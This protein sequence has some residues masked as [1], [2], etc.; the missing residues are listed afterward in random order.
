MRLETYEEDL[1]LNDTKLTGIKEE[2]VWDEVLDFGIV[3]NY[4]VCYLHDG[5]EG[6]FNLVISLILHYYCIKTKSKDKKLLLNILNGRLKS[7]DYNRNDIS[8]RPTLV[9][10][11]ELK[12]KHLSMSGTEMHNFLLIFSMLVVDIVQH[13]E[14]WNLYLQMRQIM[15]LCS[16]RKFQKGCTKFMRTLV[17]EFIAMFKNPFPTEPIKP[18]M[19]NLTHYGTILEQSGPIINLSTSKYETKHNDKKKE[20]SAANSRVNITHTLCMEESLVLCY[21]FLSKGNLSMNTDYGP[22]ENFDR[23]SDF[24]LY[25]LFKETVLSNFINSPCLKPPWIE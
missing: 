17:E 1:V 4:A 11:V 3:E 10:E 21:R 2:S 7:F 22:V 20:A 13:D 18:K 24:A 16:S 19:H 5:P 23:L 12:D 14:V 8:N 6:T 25:Y 9:S 15:E